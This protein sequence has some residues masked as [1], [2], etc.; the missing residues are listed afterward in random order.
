MEG[1]L[2][3]LAMK[4]LQKQSA[5]LTVVPEDEPQNNPVR[6]PETGPERPLDSSSLKVSQSQRLGDETET[7]G[8]ERGYLTVA[9]M[10]ELER[11]LRLSGW[12]VERIGNDL[13][14]WTGRK[15]RY[16]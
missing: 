5:S 10:P 14:C 12:R 8:F 7:L 9:D 4:V 15:P 16:Q 2:K 13:R 3:S 6:L 1:D 11:R